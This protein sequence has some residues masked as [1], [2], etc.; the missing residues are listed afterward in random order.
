MVFSKVARWT[1]DNLGQKTVKL[2]WRFH[3]NEFIFF[4]PLGKPYKRVSLYSYISKGIE[5]W[6]YIVVII[7]WRR[8]LCGDHAWPWPRAP[9][10]AAGRGRARPP[11][12]RRRGAPLRH[13]VHPHLHPPLPS[14]R[15]AAGACS[16]RADSKDMR[17]VGY[18]SIAL[19]LFIYYHTI[20]ISNILFWSRLAHK[21]D[22]CHYLYYYYVETL[23]MLRVY[24]GL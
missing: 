15:A 8:S 6:Y 1:I 12:A 18:G 22:S 17:L 10:R 9:C 13:A 14:H 11:A 24:F 23:E 21:F 20:V 2:T 4:G 16:P 5:I 7:T 19:S 3:A